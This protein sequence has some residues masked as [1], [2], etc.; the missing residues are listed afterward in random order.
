MPRVNVSLNL[1][2]PLY[3]TLQRIKYL[4][5]PLPKLPQRNL[6]G[7]RDIEWSWVSANIPNGK[8]RAL[9]FGPGG[10]YLSLTLAHKGYDVTAVDLMPIQWYHHLPNVNLIQGDLLQ[11]PLEDASFDVIVVCSTVEHVG[12]AGRYNIT[13]YEAD[14]DL[15]AMKKL[16]RLLKVD[17]TMLLT[18]P[19]GRDAVFPPLHRVYGSRLP[20]LL[21]G[22]RVE[23]EEFWIKNEANCWIPCN[24][25]TAL[26]FEPYS[27]APNGAY[28]CYALG[29]FI[30]NKQ[31]HTS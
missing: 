7:E 4:G 12:I 31:P 23:H 24:K 20:R 21:E 9:D 5:K 16:H 8:G 29:T 25:Q 13:Q 27:Y 17:G 15:A 18:C 3:R 19:V 1:P 10:S 22:Y 11:L 26:A 6:D 14:G 30:L 2:E 28:S